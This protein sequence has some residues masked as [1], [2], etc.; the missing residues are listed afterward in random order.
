MS[1]AHQGTVSP[2]AHFSVSLPPS[3]VTSQVEIIWVD[4]G[5]ILLFLLFFLSN[6]YTQGGAWTQD[7]KIKSY[8]LHQREP[9]SRPH[10]V[11][12]MF[13]LCLSNAS[14]LSEFTKSFTSFFIHHTFSSP[15][16]PLPWIHYFLNWSTLPRNSVKYLRVANF[17]LAKQKMS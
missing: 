10:I 12:N 15:R 2:L 5:S 8:I 9:A 4:Y 17:L 7:H 11:L 6:L 1:T 13:T 3:L 16:L 14:K